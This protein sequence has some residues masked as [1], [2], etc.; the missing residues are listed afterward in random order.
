MPRAAPLKVPFNVKTLALLPA[1]IL[2]LASS[3][4][5]AGPA[6]LLFPALGR[7]EALTVAGRVLR[8]A[9]TSGTTSLSRN[10]RWLAASTWAGA[11]VEV[12]FEGQRVK[13]R[14]GH[15]GAFEVTF[16]APPGAPF[17]PGKYIVEA[18]APWGVA[19]TGVQ[20]VSNEAPFVVISDFD[21]TIAVTNVLHKAQ[22]AKAALLEESDT[23]PA[24]PGMSAF[25]DCLTED[26]AQDPGLAVVTGS[27]WQYGPRL[28]GFLAA[29]RFPFAAVYPRELSTH[30]LSHYKEPVIRALMQRLTNK[31][32]LVGDSGEKDP[33][34]YAEIRKEFPDRVAAIYIRKVR[35]VEPPDRFPGMFVFT[36]PRQAAKDALGKGFLSQA[37]FE[38][39]FGRGTP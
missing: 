25:Y 19:R 11:E 32:V 36:E 29:N 20:I 30:T 5:L 17:P 28:S 1:L 18:H 6:L 10:M 38:S 16:A 15:E 7:P 3:A 9:P 33:E 27:P 31:F 8:E 2:S 22:M 35:D 37:C 14:S 26:K 21:D 24:V 4:A 34:V 39:A 23:Q 13:A 12:A